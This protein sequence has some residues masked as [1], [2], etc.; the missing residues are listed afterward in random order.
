MTGFPY[1]LL[2]A[3][4]EAL[5]P[6]AVQMG[7]CLA[8]SPSDAWQFDG[9]GWR[10]ADGNLYAVASG[11]VGAGVVA[12]WQD[13]MQAPA[14]SPDADTVA[15]QAA[16]DATELVSSPTTP[17]AASTSIISAYL[18]PNPSNALAVVA[19]MGLTR[20]PNPNPA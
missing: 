17:V 15:A 3:V 18:A 7:I 1:R 9:T 8:A 11:V 4:P 10:D 19:A 2:V 16:Q 6:N 20:V 13:G 12:N 14:W 5:I